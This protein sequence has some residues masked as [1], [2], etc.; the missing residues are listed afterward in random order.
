M[1]ATLNET[2]PLPLPLAPPVTV[3]HP[4]LLVAVHAHPVVAL[5]FVDDAPPAAATVR[6]EGDSVTSHAAPACVTVKGCP[7]TLSVPVR[8][9]AVVFAAAVNVTEPL[10]VPLPP[11]VTASHPVDVLAV[12]AQPAGAVTFVE[13][14]PP[15]AAT[16]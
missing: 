3:S 7:A 1:A 14:L 11:L 2:V 12:H 6:L 13:P 5:T 15:P 10:L 8:A 4:V 16:D 9:C